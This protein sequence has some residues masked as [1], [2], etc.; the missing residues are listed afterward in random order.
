LARRRLS[1]RVLRSL[2]GQ[3]GPGDGADPRLDRGEVHATKAARKASQLCAQVAEALS[4][5]LAATSGDDAVAGLTVVAV[6]PAP[7][8][9]RLR[10][11]VAPPPGDP[12][13]PEELLAR[14]ERAAPRLRG[15]VARSITRRRAPTLA[16][17]L[18]LA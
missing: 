15:E 10:V 2:C 4:F 3:I 18:S 6:E 11:T 8:T 16:F 14:L 1:T 17:R 5:A 7:D 9:T 13:G 12:I